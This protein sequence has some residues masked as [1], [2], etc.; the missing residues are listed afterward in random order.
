[1]AGET[2]FDFNRPGYPGDENAGI[3]PPRQRPGGLTAICVIAIVLGALGLCSS[4]FS[5]GVNAFQGQLQ[6]LAKQQQELVQKARNEEFKQQMETQKK[7]FDASQRVSDR[8]SGTRSATAILNLLVSANLLAGAIATLKLGAKGRQFLIGVFLA[9]I[10][11]EILRAIVAVAAGLD[12][13]AE[14]SAIRNVAGQSAE[15]QMTIARA[16]AIGTILFSVVMAVGMG[17]FYAVG[18]SYLRRP[19]VLAL[20]EHLA[21]DRI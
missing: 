9:A 17:V 15:M 3:N 1:M 2:P 13:V 20:F 6:A 5:L 4:L 11:F 18:F 14:L 8:H 21:A 7:I 12:V 16:S 10:V 19:K